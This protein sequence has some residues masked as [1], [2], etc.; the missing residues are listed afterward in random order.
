MPHASRIF[1]LFSSLM[2]R[3]VALLGEMDKVK[4]EASKAFTLF[5]EFKK[6]AIESNQAVVVE[7][8]P[9]LPFPSL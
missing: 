5:L 9:G 4:A 7:S 2:D 6:I 3:E 1:P 8:E